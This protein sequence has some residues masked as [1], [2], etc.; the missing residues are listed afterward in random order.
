MPANKYKFISPGVFLNEIDNSFLPGLSEDIGPVLIGRS[1]KGPAFIP[2]RV[3]SFADFIDT[4]GAPIAGGGI[5]S[6]FR[7]APSRGDVWRDGNY[8]GPTYAPYA[9]QAY[10]DSAAPITFVRV[11]GDDHEKASATGYAGWPAGGSTDYTPD[12]HDGGGAVGLFLANSSSNVAEDFNVTGA[13]AAIWYLKSGTS[14]RLQGDLMGGGS[15][16]AGNEESG[17]GQWVLDTGAD[18]TF[19]A[20]IKNAGSITNY[21]ASFNF[22]PNSERFIRKVFNTNPQLTNTS[23]IS[24]T[25]KG[26]STYWLGPTY[27]DFVSRNVSKA[28][29]GEVIGALLAI[30]S[31]SQGGAGSAH[32]MDF[33]FGAK[34]GKTGWFFTQDFGQATNFRPENAQKLFRF[35]TLNPDEWTQRNLKISIANVR[36]ASDDYNAYGMFDVEVRKVHDSD[37]AKIVVEKYVGCNLNPHSPDYIAKKIGDINLAWDYDERVYKEYGKYA[38]RSKYFYVEMDDRVDDGMVRSEVLPF[39]VFGPPRFKQVQVSTG[40]LASWPGNAQ[41]SGTLQ[42]CFVMGTGT[43]PHVP[44][45]EDLAYSTLASGHWGVP[46]GVGGYATD[47]G[48]NLTGTLIF[49]SFPLVVSAS[50]V[51]TNS[52]YDAYFGIDVYQNGSNRKLADEYVDLVRAMPE[53]YD[54]TS[55][56]TDY[57]YIFTLDDIKQSTDGSGTKLADAFYQSGSR[58]LD[59]SIT[60][61]NAAAP[62]TAHSSASYASVLKAGFNNYTTCFYGGFDG[63]DVAEKEPLRNSK[64]NSS[65]DEL[66]NYAYHSV[67]R[68]LDSIADPEVVEFNVAALPGITNE[69]LTG[70]LIDMCEDRGDALA[71]IDLKGDYTA[72]TENNSA[73][74]SRKG[75]VKDVVDNLQQRR[76]NSS[77]GCAYYPWVTVRDKI[78]GALVNVPPSVVALGV[79][80]TTEAV[81]DL[82]FAPAGF[83]RGGL[84]LGA[85]GLPVVATKDKLTSKDRDKLYEANINPIA[86]F[87]AEG[88]VVFGQKTLQVQRSALDRINV[89]RL[90]IFV[91]KE[92]ARIANT[93][94]FEQNVQATWDK[95]VSSVNPVLQDIQSRFGLTSFK[96]LLDETTTT[97]D[98]VDRNILYA[99]IYLQPARSIEFIAVDFIINN[100]GAGFA[101]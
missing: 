39:G 2:T 78:N 51:G 31:G 68:A 13:L 36:V 33:R 49:P 52:Q 61:D 90:L 79:F 64:L 97:P 85:A 17:S 23:I 94:L 72:R 88:I 9:A 38:N 83:T 4:F 26:Y 28:A 45:V 67:N 15:I 20:V 37:R 69:T 11:V 73:E 48:Q 3:E 75:T 16:P 30:A 99:K 47:T 84:S 71:I 19:K 87:P 35:H 82:W 1:E 6:T 70:K 21:T 81:D 44:P 57:Q 54:E 93:I 7:G 14:I 89:R 8:S 10:L 5:K 43:L 56:T 41:E 66:A 34:K 25:T 91:K 46:W 40:E 27:E 32:G 22:N 55:T 100:T 101:D 12:A 96:V 95:F 76:I 92:I 58:V 98:L 29:S 77:Y 86:T 42:D 59:D 24:A 60:V 50:D 65:E 18:K 53:G 80:G 63:F 74:T 62:L